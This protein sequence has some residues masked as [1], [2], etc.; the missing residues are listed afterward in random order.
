MQRAEPVD[1]GI[2]GFS[3]HREVTHPLLFLEATQRDRRPDV[4]ERKK[5]L[6]SAA[7]VPRN[8]IVMY[9]N[10]GEGNFDSD[11]VLGGMRD[12]AAEVERVRMPSVSQGLRRKFRMWNEGLLREDRWRMSEMWRREVVRSLPGMWSYRDLHQTNPGVGK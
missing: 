1:S 3:L 9:Q 6:A 4:L 2:P 12:D 11:R 5:S 8:V 7:R 10:V